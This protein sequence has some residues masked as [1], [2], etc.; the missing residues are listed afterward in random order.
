MDRSH[1]DVDHSLENTVFAAVD[2]VPIKDLLFRASYRHS[3][4]KPDTY[5]D[6]N[7][8]DPVTGNFVACTATTTVSFTC[9]PGCHR[10]IYDASR[11][12]NRADGLVQSTPI[13]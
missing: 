1:R 13:Y 3:D 4:R 6:D 10:R 9:D 12:R 2:W 11:L 8:I 5:R 7:S